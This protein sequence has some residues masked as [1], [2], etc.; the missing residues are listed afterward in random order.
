MA[1]LPI[2]MGA[3]RVEV[4]YGVLKAITKLKTVPTLIKVWVHIQKQWHISLRVRARMSLSMILS[5]DQA[6]Q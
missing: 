4:Y 6:E 5:F 3:L 1:V 2:F